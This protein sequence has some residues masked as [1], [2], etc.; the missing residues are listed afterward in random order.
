MLAFKQY[1]WVMI[2]LTFAFFIVGFYYPLHNYDQLP[3]RIP[4]HFNFKGD[5]DS[6]SDKNLG[7]L[8]LGQLMALP[9]VLIMLPFVWWA[10]TVKD[11]R[12]IISGPANKVTNMSLDRAEK[13]RGLT[14]FHLLLMAMLIALL[15]MYNSVQQVAVA[16][17]R[18]TGLGWGSPVIL[19]F[20]LGDCAVLTWQVVRLI[21]K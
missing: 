13:V 7:S 14:I 11:P 12:K 4:T 1:H 5:P 16:L 8:L 6:W 21:Y 3:D 15:I 10:A 9:S 19:A 18:N 17:G 2:I 20:I